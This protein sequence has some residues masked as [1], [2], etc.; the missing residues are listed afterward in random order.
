M[1]PPLISVIMPSYNSAETI[2]ATLGSLDKQQFRDFELVVMD[3][4]SFDSTIR[5]VELLASVDERV[6]LFSEKDKGI[7]DAMNKGIQAASGTWLYF[8]GSDDR[9]YD[10]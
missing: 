8:L 3:G 7:Y 4:G 10:D 2:R 6:R 9:L 1:Q 5:I